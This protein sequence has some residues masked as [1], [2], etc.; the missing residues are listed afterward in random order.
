MGIILGIF[1]IGF[2][3]AIGA[4]FGKVIGYIGCFFI[5]AYY[6]ISEWIETTYD[7]RHEL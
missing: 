4:F 6:N 3:I 2:A 1:W 7:N 5:N